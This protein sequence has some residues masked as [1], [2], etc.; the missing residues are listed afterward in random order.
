MAAAGPNGPSS[1]SNPRKFSEKIALQ[2]QRQ[3]EETA[4]FEEVMMDI[5]STRLQAQKLRL[6]H[7]RGP[8]YGG[9]LPN[10]NQIGNNTAEFPGSF[11]SNL[12]PS[13]STRHHGLVERVHR[14]RRMMSP[15]RRYM[16]QIDSSP[17]SSAYL[18]PPPEP[19][20]RRNIPWG[21]FPMEKGHL[22]RLPSALNRTNSDSAL[23]TSVMNPNPQDP[24]AGASQGMSQSRRSGQLDGEMDNKAF[25]FPVPPIDENLLDAKKFT[26]ASTRPKSCEVPGINIFPSP[27]QTASIAL[28]PAALNTGGSLPDL[29]NLHFPS[30]L[31]TPLDP[32]ESAFPSLSGGNSTSNLANTMT[33][34]G[35]SGSMGMVPRYESLGLSSPLSNTL[36]NASLQSSLSN[37][38]IQSSLSSQSLSSSL[39]NPS[40]QSSLSSPPLQ[41]SLSSRSFQ[42]SLSNPSIQSS[43]VNPTMQST[44]SSSSSYPAMGSPLSSTSM[45]TSPRR[46]TPLT[47]PVGGD[48]RRH[49]HK[50][51]SPTMSPTLSSITQGVPLDTSHLPSD[52]RLPV[53]PY[54]QSHLLLQ[55]QQQS[56]MQQQ[57]QPQPPP[58]LQQQQQEQVQQTSQQALQ[59]SQT[60]GTTQQQYP[61]PYQQPTSQMQLG[62]QLTD[63]NLSSTS[64]PNSV[65]EDNYF[66]SQPTAWQTKPQS[67]QYEQFNVDSSVNSLPLNNNNTAAAT[68]FIRHTSALNFLQAESVGLTGSNS[69]L[70]DPQLLNKQN[71]N[72]LSRHG[73]IP[74]IILTGDSPPGFSKEITNALAGIPGFE[75]DAPFGLDEDLKIEPF[76]LEGLNMLSDPYIVL[77]DPSVEDSFRTDRLQ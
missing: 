26:T 27:D 75:M 56:A 45:S 15:L 32:E 50:Q 33:Q 59:H 76:T 67:Q 4:A 37:P 61:S 70:H 12:D 9:S 42:P 31:P 30:P 20:W 35:I 71:Q 46:R 34:L 29:T 2:K 54:G 24:F 36:R 73:T 52:Q 19:S 77:P 63:F 6:A 40:L 16:R 7:S 10:V 58:T 17:Y 64:L 43:A 28:L 68:T 57:Q 14:D 69:S 22:C 38:N 18:S 11:H 21:N 51:F 49:H 47:L 55:S 13:R 65:L 53:Y 62:H 1:A 60:S 39:S 41:S 72:N 23:H 66:D 5:S 8:Y 25:L 44:F 3:A 48:S 74:N